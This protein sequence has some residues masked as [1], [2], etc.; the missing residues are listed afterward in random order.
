MVPAA[1]LAKLERASAC[2]ADRGRISPAISGQIG[3]RM[4]VRSLSIGMH[5][6]SVDVP[7][8]ESLKN[9]KLT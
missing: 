4:C 5:E 9:R 7:E 6:N 1:V 3:S 2:A 8:S